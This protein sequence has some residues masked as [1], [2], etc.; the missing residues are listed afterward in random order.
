VNNYKEVESPDSM[1]KPLTG[2]LEHMSKNLL[3]TILNSKNA[4]CRVVDIIKAEDIKLV[5]SP[6]LTSTGALEWTWKKIKFSETI[7]IEEKLY[8]FIKYFDIAQSNRDWVVVNPKGEQRYIRVYTPE[9]NVRS[10]DLN[11]GEDCQYD[12]R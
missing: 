12:N 10:R 3:D 4:A 6:Y 2:A 5:S 7:L 9:A 1:G 8:S 11:E